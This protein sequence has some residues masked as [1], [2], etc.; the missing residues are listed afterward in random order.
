M[1]SAQNRHFVSR[2]SHGVTQELAAEVRSA[3]GAQ[4][5][6]ERQLATTYDGSADGLADWWPD[7]HLDPKEL[8]DQQV[9]QTRGGYRVMYDCGTA[10]LRSAP[11]PAQERWGAREPS[12]PAS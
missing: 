8:W 3:G 7:L 2:F 10:V 4:K 12:S 9:D 11:V 6:F 5:W 1:L